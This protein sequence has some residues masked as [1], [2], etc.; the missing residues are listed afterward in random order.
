MKEVF[1]S[2]AESQDKATKVAKIRGLYPVIT[3]I[4]PLPKCKFSDEESKQNA[5]AHAHDNI[6]ADNFGNI[7]IAN[8]VEIFEKD[9]KT[10]SATIL[11]EVA[12]LIV[13]K[14]YFNG[15][16]TH[17]EEWQDFYNILRNEWG[18]DTIQNPT[19]HN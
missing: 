7:C 9:G 11:H 3:R 13:A 5:T 17:G 6:L 12:H 16:D 2:L 15:V 8:G 10:P 18:Y 19:T 14:E 4:S 1:M